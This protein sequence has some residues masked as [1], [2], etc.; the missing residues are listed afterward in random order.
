[1]SVVIW[2]IGEILISTGAVVIIAEHS[3]ASHVARFQSQYDM[4]R[5]VGRGLGPFLF[6]QMLS[7]LNYRQTWT[8]DAAAC[9]II[10]AYC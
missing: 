4:A 3:P 10:A 6:G 7:V 2:S 9:I 8:I 5:S 1:M